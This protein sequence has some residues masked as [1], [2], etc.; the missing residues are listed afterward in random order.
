MNPSCL[1][2][3]SLV[4]ALALG[5]L[6]LAP[7]SVRAQAAPTQAATAE[8]KA[9][10]RELA[11]SGINLAQEGKCQEAIDPLLRA[12]QLFH[13]PT[14]LTWIGECQIRIGRLVEGSETLRE[15][16]REELPSDAPSA[17]ID[18]QKRAARLIE[19]TAPKIGKLTIVVQTSD[20]P[21]ADRSD[22]RVLVDGAAISHALIGAPRPTDPGTHEVTAAL[23][24][25]VTRVAQVVIA[26]GGRERLTLELLPERKPTPSAS[27]SPTLND[28]AASSPPGSAPHPLGWAL[29]GGGAAF[30]AGGGAL[31][32]IAM[33]EKNALDCPTAATCPESER[34]DLKKARLFATLSTV[35]FGVGAAAAVAGVVV[36]LTT[37][38]QHEETLATRGDEK[39]EVH[40]RPE[41]AP[42]GWASVGFS[43]T[44]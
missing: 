39:S 11:I 3:P 2:R 43:G 20:G 44:F 17:F 38:G 12:E 35:S 18:A 10:A 34:N 15:V 28:A 24:G 6:S 5:V 13:A 22:L 32:F 40:V 25:Y 16:V 7:Q 21:I 29:V 30:L 14:I 37:G 26:D 4:G 27:E 42:L 1:F 36:L 31:G 33:S 9:A 41:F 23:P 19:E 8:E